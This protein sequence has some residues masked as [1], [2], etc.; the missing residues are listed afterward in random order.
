MTAKSEKMCFVGYPLNAKGYRL[1]VRCDV[2]FDKTNFG[3]KQPVERSVDVTVTE[4]SET[5]AVDSV[6]PD[7]CESAGTQQ[8]L[9]TTSPMTMPSL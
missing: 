2:V 4:R 3:T 9:P 8:S 5:V 7:H 1:Y 6:L